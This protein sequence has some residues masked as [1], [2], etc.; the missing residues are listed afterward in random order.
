M[1]PAN[2]YFVRVTSKYISFLDFIQL[3]CCGKMIENSMPHCWLACTFITI[4]QTNTS[5]F[6]F[7][8]IHLNIHYQIF[9]ILWIKPVIEKITARSMVN[10]DYY[11]Y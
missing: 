3:Q 4:E 9:Y 1:Y 8:S 2:E 11:L 5:L 6:R 10:D 7:M